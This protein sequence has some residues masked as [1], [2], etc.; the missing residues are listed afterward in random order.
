MKG[1]MQVNEARNA[2]LAVGLA[3]VLLALAFALLG[4][5]HVAPPEEPAAFS[6][7]DGFAGIGAGELTGAAEPVSLAVGVEGDNSC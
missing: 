4:A 5:S 1:G 2:L 3:V 7:L 6:T